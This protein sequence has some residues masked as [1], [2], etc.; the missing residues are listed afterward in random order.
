MSFASTSGA[1]YLALLLF[2][3]S[4]TTAVEAVRISQPPVIDGRLLDIQ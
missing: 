4:V 3:P 1:I 2:S